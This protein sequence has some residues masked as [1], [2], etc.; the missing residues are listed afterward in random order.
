MHVFMRII[1]SE[2]TYPYYVRTSLQL[3]NFVLKLV[4]IEPSSTLPYFIHRAWVGAHM[5]LG[6][7]AA[8]VP[9]RWAGDVERVI[10]PILCKKLLT[11]TVN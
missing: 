6:L 7:V 8:G 5:R 4:T 11:I 2:L 9:G 1:T 3:Q 10:E